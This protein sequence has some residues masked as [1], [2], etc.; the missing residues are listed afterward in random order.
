MDTP[1]DTGKVDVD[2]SIYEAD[3]ETL[4]QW[5]RDGHVTPGTRVRKGSLAWIELGRAPAFRDMFSGA[6]PAGAVAY[7]PPAEPPAAGVCVNHPYAAA[8]YVCQE[9]DAS[10]CIPCVKRYGNAA[11]CTLCGQLCRPYAVAQTETARRTELATGY[12]LGD[13]WLACRY[14]LK[15]PVALAIT[16]GLY[17]FLLMFGFYGKLASAG[18]LFGYMSH[19]VRRVSMGHYDEGPSPDLS[20]P[21]DLVFNAGKLG[22][23]VT[24]V[25]LG[26]LAAV[27]TFGISRGG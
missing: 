5:I 4:V 23:A 6:A 13:L 22:I 24:L 17:G 10:L 9:C 8:K 20:D 19:A 14:P 27:I 7:A 1:T 26:P 2:G 25:T 3:S 16:A 21:A 11:V 15:D 12:G 18:L